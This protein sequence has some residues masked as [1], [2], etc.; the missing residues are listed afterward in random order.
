[1]KLSTKQIKDLKKFDITLH[2]IES[3]AKRTGIKPEDIIS[4]YN[5]G[6]PDFNQLER[7]AVDERSLN[8]QQVF[9]KSKASNSI[10]K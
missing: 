10:K 2:K 8:R 5:F 4:F 3:S 9:E 1:M 7:E 6:F